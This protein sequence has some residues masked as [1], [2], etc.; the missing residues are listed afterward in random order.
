MCQVYILN[1]HLTLL[2]LAVKAAQDFLSQSCECCDQHFL[3][4]VEDRF[5][6][7]WG[8]HN[9]PLSSTLLSQ[10]FRDYQPLALIKIKSFSLQSVD[11]LSFPLCFFQCI[12]SVNQSV[13]VRSTCLVDVLMIVWSRNWRTTNRLVGVNIIHLLMLW[14]KAA[15]HFSCFW[16]IVLQGCANNSYSTWVIISSNFLYSVFFV[17]MLAKK[18]NPY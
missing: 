6:E 10:V 14:H 4:S 11:L 7:T 3:G 9:N 1:P 17:K 15:V 12:T 8:V 2:D 5:D 18:A 13:A 16:E